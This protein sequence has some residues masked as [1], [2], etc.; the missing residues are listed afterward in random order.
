[1]KSKFEFKTF[2]L[3]TKLKY[4]LIQKLKIIKINK[5]NHLINNSTILPRSRSDA[6]FVTIRVAFTSLTVGCF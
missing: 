4:H 6:S 3:D 1:M 5:F 2:G